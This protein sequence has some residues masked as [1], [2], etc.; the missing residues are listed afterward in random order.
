MTS[1]LTIAASYFG[2]LLVG[3]QQT[4][5]CS[6]QKNPLAQRGKLRKHKGMKMQPRK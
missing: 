6:Y 1:P 4:I 2:V 5:Y 3:G